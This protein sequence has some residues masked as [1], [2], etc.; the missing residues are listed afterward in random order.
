MTDYGH[1][2]LFGS[3]VTPVARP[4]QH[5][6][7]LAI[8]SERAGLDLVTFQ[9]HPY[10]PSFHD[11]STLLTYVASQTERIALSGNVTSLPLR[12]PLGLARTAATVDRLSGGRFRLGIGAGAFWDG[13]AGMGGRRLSPGQGAAALK[14]AI[15][16]IRDAWDPEQTGPINY[17]GRFYRV[18][19][20]D[21]APVAHGPIPIWVGSY[22]PRMLALTGAVGDGWLPSIEYIEGGL[23]GLADANTRIDDAAREAGRDPAAVRRLMNFMRA[24]IAPAGQGFLDGPPQAW[25]D[26]LTMLALDHGVSAFLVGGDDPTTIARFGAEIAPAVRENVEHA[27]QPAKTASQAS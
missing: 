6:V 24:S 15:G 8:A 25:V 23:R 7:D 3:F 21:R 26:R 20:G 9:D 22:K 18:T 16:L 11:T 17:E 27:R 5:A 1:D 10:Q 2:L 12:P 13:I 4:A 19:D 14:E